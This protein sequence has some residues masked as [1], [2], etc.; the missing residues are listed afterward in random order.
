MMSHEFR[1]PLGTTLMFIEM[2]LSMQTNASA[3]RII[4]LIK[5][6]LNLLLS[7]VNDMVDLK[8]I[9]ENNFVVNL[10]VFDP[11]SAL[12]FIKELFKHNLESYNI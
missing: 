6:S 11:R 9:K 7:L 10:N 2:I 3:I 4:E 5:D 12:D 1:T 8:L